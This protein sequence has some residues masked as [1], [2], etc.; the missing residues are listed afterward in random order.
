MYAIPCCGEVY[1]GE[2]GCSIKTRLKEPSVNIQ[3]IHHD[4]INK[5]IVVEHLYTSSHHMCL[6]ESRV[7]ARILYYYKRKIREAIKIEKNDNNIN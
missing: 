4:R 3:N 2:I 1:I 6:E 7:L 5:S